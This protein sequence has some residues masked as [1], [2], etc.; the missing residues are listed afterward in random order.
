MC[1]SL[2]ALQQ[3]LHHL[4]LPEYTWLIIGKVKYCMNLYYIHRNTH[5]AGY[6]IYQTLNVV[7]YCMYFH[8]LRETGLQCKMFGSELHCSGLLCSM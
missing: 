5:T 1:V 6:H 2:Q 4:V 3:M 8:I 7:C